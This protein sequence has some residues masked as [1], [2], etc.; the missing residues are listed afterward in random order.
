MSY[1]LKAETR[2]AALKEAVAY[3]R[4]LRLETPVLD[5]RLIVQHALGTDWEAL[6]LGPDHALND[7]DRARVSTG[8]ARRAA[9]EPVARIIGRR[10]FWTL[11]L[12]VSPATLDPRPD[13][14]SLIEAV[15]AELPDRT[16]PLRILD[17][18]TGTG[19]LLLAL[20][21]EYKNARGIGVDSSPGATLVANL[22]AE[23]HR[24]NDRATI[25]EGNWTEGLDGPFDLIVSNPP[26]I[27][28]GEIARLPAEV[29]DYDPP[30]A[31]DGGP[32]GLDAYRRIL[33]AVSAVLAPTGLVVLEVGAGQMAAV[34]A[35]A[36]EN[37]LA[38]RARRLDLA[39]I[40]RALVLA[41]GAP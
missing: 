31:L 27:P 21:S 4:S 7:D 1:A 11:D 28:S 9:R 38:E 20:L 32:D 19:A 17:L 12:H 35:L 22:N 33:M 26:Y 8:L 29:R 15:V 14:E 16:L 34:S 30:G 41:R 6:F 18:G 2:R 24:L 37:G 36:G 3:L 13:T 39:G 40:E 5:A 25:R 10:H 23:T